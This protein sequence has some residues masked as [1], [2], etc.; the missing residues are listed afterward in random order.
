[1]RYETCGTKNGYRDHARKYGDEP[2]EECSEALR[3]YWR[4]YRS[5]PEV[6]ER[7]AIYNR[8]VRNIR[9]SS[10]FKKLKANGFDPKK[11]HYSA[12]TVLITYGESCH[13]CGEQI[14]LSAPRTP[15]KPGWER[16]LH[17]DHVIPLSKGGDDILENVR[18]SHGKCNIRKNNK[19]E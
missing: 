4:E 13:L 18:P 5:R 9:Y 6:K 16:S 8:T 19:W 17:I 3:S 15:G 7:T 12:N 14:D 2:C 1:M 10:R 11:D